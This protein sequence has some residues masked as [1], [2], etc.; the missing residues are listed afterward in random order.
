MG[1]TG[2]WDRTPSGPRAPPQETSMATIHRSLAEQEGTY[3]LP[4]LV[5][6]WLAAPVTTEGP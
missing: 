5:G 3:W 1:G 2:A 4:Q 6:T